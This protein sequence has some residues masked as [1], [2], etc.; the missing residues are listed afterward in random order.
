[1]E[2]RR[3]AFGNMA[4]GKRRRKGMNDNPKLNA[5]GYKDMTAYKAIVNTD[6]KQRKAASIKSEPPMVFICS[7]FAGNTNANMA[8][9]LKYCRFALNKG[10]FPIAPHCYFPHFMDDSKPAERELAISFGLK[11]LCQCRELW[12]FGAHISEG[13]K[14]EILAAK[15]NGI[16]IRQFNENMEEVHHGTNF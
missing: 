6:R 14:K 3:H 7:P 9:A 16:R 15:W 5:S 10:K 4:D 2:H 1:M 13:M 11:L 8:K 12:I